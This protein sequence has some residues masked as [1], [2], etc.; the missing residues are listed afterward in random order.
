MPAAWKRSTGPCLGA[1]VSVLAP[2]L[3]LAAASLAACAGR[4]DPKPL[5]GRVVCVDAGHGGTAATDSYRVGPGGEREEWIDLR[6][7]KIL[8]RELERRG[9]RVLM[10]RT[11]DV[12]VDLARRAE[13]AVAGRADLFVSVHH[14]AAA[15]PAVDFPVVYFH[16]NASENLA[17]VALGRAVA[18]R[19]DQALFEGRGTP[20]LVSDFAIFPGTGAAVLR[21]SYG[22]PGV[23]SEASFFTDPDEELRLRDEGYD[24]REAQALAL[25]VQDF[26]ALPAPAMAD[27]GSRIELPPFVVFQE[28]ERMKPEARQWRAAY[29]EARQLMARGDPESLARAYERLVFSVR[30]FPDSPIAGECHRLRS[31]ILARQGRPDEA[32]TERRRS[33]EHYVDVASASE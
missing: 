13:V 4:P 31:E 19:L 25:A 1:A 28:A 3:L 26:L 32:Q 10:T 2:A 20:A 21:L 24:R 17:G 14:N 6:V 8:R 29:D 5:A 9:A 18:S 15:D 23:I 27:V 7:A 16:G 12:A 11:G 33:A 30:A 22:I